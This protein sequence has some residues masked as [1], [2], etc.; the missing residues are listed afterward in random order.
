MFYLCLIDAKLWYLSRIILDAFLMLN[1]RNN[2][3]LLMFYLR[4]TD[5]KLWYLSRIILDAF[6]TL[7]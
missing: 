1:R 6:L 2:D 4:L 5:A 3:A 7:Y